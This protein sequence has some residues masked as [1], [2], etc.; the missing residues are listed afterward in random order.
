MNSLTHKNHTDQ[1]VEYIASVLYSPTTFVTKFFNCATAC[2]ERR[3]SGVGVNGVTGFQLNLVATVV[4]C[5]AK[6]CSV[7][8]IAITTSPV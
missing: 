4:N 7:V 2:D 3:R 1:M 8:S 5:V 6:E